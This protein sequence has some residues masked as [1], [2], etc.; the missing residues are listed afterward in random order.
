MD[1]LY[2]KDDAL[3]DQLL[4]R[5]ESLTFD[6]KRIGK[7]DKVLHTIVAFANTQGGIIALGFEDSDKAQGRARVL[8]IQSDPMQYDE[9]KRKLTTRIT[10]P[11][12]LTISTQQIGCTI[13]DG[14]DGWV[15]ILK[16]AKSRR[17]HSIVDNGTFVRLDKS[18]KE[19]TATEI[20]KLMYDRG[21]VSAESQL[22][23]VDFQLLETPYWA[24][25]SSQRRLTRRID[26]AMYNV[27][28]AKKNQQGVL[29][30][31]RAAV[32]L[33][34]EDPSGLLASK[35]TVRVFHYR[36]N[37]TSND[38]NTNLVRPPTTIRGPLI[39]QIRDAREVI[40]NELA[41]GVQ[42]GPL[43]FEIIQKYPVRVITEAITNAV[44]HRDYSLQA[45]TIVKI[46]SDR[47][48]IESP[49]L[50]IGPVRTAN[51]RRIGSYAR[52][53]LIVQHLR[54]FPNP[55]NLDAGEG[56]PMMF[57][58]MDEAGLYPPL[59]STRPRLDRDAVRVFLLNEHRPSVWQQV[60]EYLDKNG[61]IN[62]S[63]VRKLKQTQ[64]TLGVSKLLKSWVDQGFLEVANPGA[65]RNV[66]C[67]RKPNDD[68]DFFSNLIGKEP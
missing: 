25:Y 1:D 45:D 49:G 68:E 56:V 24:E 4:A 12:Q 41:G 51:I 42:F 63:D 33:F 16:V 62:N 20:N 23:D 66:R 11:D 13:A 8:G 39:R 55:P 53:S 6:C 44:I 15:A 28:L 67:Y 35:A 54:E 40:V 9:L 19:L 31:L 48:E 50:L 61:T 3:V 17:V 58:T 65:G 29:K 14:S 10:E 46:F 30:P 36:G 38:P 43:G 32:L 57:G 2:L 47:I 34:A 18:N 22:E 5:P 26:Q 21:V 59:Y 37:E 52:N 60:S 7:L 27:G 64:D